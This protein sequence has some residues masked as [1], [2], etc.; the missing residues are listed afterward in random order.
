MTF[1]TLTFFVFLA[2][3]LVLYW[4]LRERGPQNTLLI[5]ASLVFYGWWDWRFCVLMLASTCVDYVAALV[6]ASSDDPRVRRMAMIASAMVCMGLLAFFKYFNFF[7]ESFAT[8]AAA[9]GWHVDTLTLRVVLPVGISFYTFQSMSY[10][11]DVYRGQLRAC[12]S[13][14]DYLAFVTFFPQLVAGPVN[15]ASHL[16]GEFQRDREFDLSEAVD[17]CRQA[18][19]GLFKKMV[20]AD[21]LAPL[22]DAAYTEPEAYSGGRLVLATVFFA[23][24]IYCDFSGYSDIAIGVSKFFGVTLMRNFAYPYF[25]RDIGEFWRRWH[26]SLSTW[27]RDY[28]YIPLG[29]SRGTRAATAAVV[30]VTFLLSGLWHGAAWTYVVWGALNGVASLPFA[31]SRAASRRSVKDVPG[32][33]RLLPSASDLARMIVTFVFVCFAWIFFRSPTIAGAA[34]VISRIVADPSWGARPLASMGPLN[35]SR[36]FALIGFLLMVEWFQREHPH[37]LIFRSSPRF[38]RWAIYCGLTWATALL[39][40]REPSSFIYFQF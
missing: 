6:M 14:R 24:Q 28:V 33:E 27:F 12:R 38:V 17:G 18:L 31:L 19:W 11:I 7:A 3:V 32:G 16:L 23:F 21:N 20:I 10:T 8:T 26:I 1:T 9:F 37:P 29:G 2:L 4:L 22:V 35:E 34:S 36:M 30:L 15:R 40:P 25:S 39:M 5:I 13:F